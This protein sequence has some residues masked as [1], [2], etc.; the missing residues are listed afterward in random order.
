MNVCVLGMYVFL[1]KAEVQ[2]ETCIKNYSCF[3]KDMTLK[4]HKSVWR[5]YYFYMKN[6]STFSGLHII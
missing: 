1:L 4:I 5:L 2:N 3:I 6:V